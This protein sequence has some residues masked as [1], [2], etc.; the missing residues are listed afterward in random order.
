MDRSSIATSSTKTIGG[1]VNTIADTATPARGAKRVRE[2]TRQGTRG[3]GLGQTESQSGGQSTTTT[4]TTQPPTAHFAAQSTATRTT[5][6]AP[7]A[8]HL[9]KSTKTTTPSASQP[10][11]ITKTRTTT[12]HHAY[13]SNVSDFSQINTTIRKKKKKKKD[14]SIELIL[15]LYFNLLA[16]TI[17]AN[18]KKTTLG[19]TT[20]SRADGKLRAVIRSGRELN[21]KQKLMI[22]LTRNLLGHSQFQ[23]VDQYALGILLM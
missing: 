19:L 6:T 4:Q 7:S 22:D 12:Q 5:T 10:V 8:S 1:R 2:D 18:K 15:Y 14:I 21:K 3:Q 23:E 13:K 9:V 16:S 17:F 11:K 20:R